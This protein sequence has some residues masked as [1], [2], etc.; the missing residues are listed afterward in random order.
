MSTIDPFDWFPPGILLKTLKNVRTIQ[1]EDR[2]IFLR[3]HELVLVLGGNRRPGTDK[4]WVINLLSQE[5]VHLNMF[6]RLKGLDD[7]EWL[8][9]CF[10]RVKD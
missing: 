7:L 6:L 2:L 3:P 10:E 8:L 5:G 4:E 1:N 9:S